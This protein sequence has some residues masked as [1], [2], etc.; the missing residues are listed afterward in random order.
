[1]LIKGLLLV[2]TTFCIAAN[3]LVGQDTGAKDTLGFDCPLFGNYATGETLRIPIYVVTDQELNPVS[4]VFDYSCT[5]VAFVGAQLSPQIFAAGGNTAFTV[6]EVDIPGSD[7]SAI[8]IW[9]QRGFEWGLEPAPIF[10]PSPQRQLFVTA[11]F[12]IL[13]P[14]C[15]PLDL[16]TISSDEL[17]RTRFGGG[18][19]YTPVISACSPLFN[20]VNFPVA[21]DE[22]AV[23]FNSLNKVSVPY[24]NPFNANVEFTISISSNQLVNA[25]IYDILGRQVR[26]FVNGNLHPGVFNYS[27][28]GTDESGHSAASGVYFLRVAS[29]SGVETR[30]LVLLR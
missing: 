12:L 22:I 20:S 13:N 16:D 11:K 4:C 9:I 23:D 8:W 2:A 10:E 28:D 7:R 14:S 30:K 3:P 27:W 15:C 6:S 19:T 29:S 18:V 26:S 24:P 17:H 5:S 21:I 1:M 25:A